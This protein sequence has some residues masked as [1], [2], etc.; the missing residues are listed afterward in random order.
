MKEQD[1]WIWINCADKTAQIHLKN[2]SSR[3]CKNASDLTK[4]DSEIQVDKS[5]SEIT[6]IFRSKTGN[7][8]QFFDL[9][10]IESS[11]FR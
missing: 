10:T 1:F 11:K 9:D 6:A 5:D 3:D 2:I 8:L 4:S 7:S